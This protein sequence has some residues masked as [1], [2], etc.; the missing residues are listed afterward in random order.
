MIP[1]MLCDRCKA[2]KEM[3]KYTA[4]LWYLHEFGIIGTWEWYMT[5]TMP[6]ETA[7]YMNCNCTYNKVV[8]HTIGGKP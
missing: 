2:Y 6:N 3:T 7:I 1:L 8:M 5:A 4:Y